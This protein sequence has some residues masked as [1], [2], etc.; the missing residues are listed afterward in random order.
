MGLG[1]WSGENWIASH[2]DL[3]PCDAFSVLDGSPPMRY[4]MD[5]VP[6]NAME[7]LTS[8]LRKAPAGRHRDNGQNRF[9]PWFQHNGRLQQYKALYSK[10]PDQNSWF[11]S[12]WN[13]A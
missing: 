13:D 8:R 12:Y 1:R 5:K 2:P 7:N 3:K 4:D 10:T 6:N 11:H 9:H